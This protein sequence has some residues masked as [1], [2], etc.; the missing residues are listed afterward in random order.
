MVLT[1]PVPITVTLISNSREST[2]T[3]TRPPEEDTS[4]EPSSWI[5]SQEPWTPSEL[6]LSVN[7]SDPTTSSSDKPCRKQLGQGSLH[8]GCRAYRLRPRCCQKGSRRM[9]LPPRFPGHP[10]PRW[11]Y[12]IRY[13]NPPHLQDQRRVPR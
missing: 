5:S 13:G 8:R 11:W 7:S 3:S 1:Q 4:P 12:R 6:D 9:R 2:S 10:L